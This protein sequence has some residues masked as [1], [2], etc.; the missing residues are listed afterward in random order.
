MGEPP[1]E[2]ARAQT[3]SLVVKQ[4]KETLDALPDFETKVAPPV[5]MPEGQLASS[6]A[7][8]GQ[9]AGAF[10]AAGI[11]PAAQ[12]YGGAVMSKTRRRIGLCLAAV[13]FVPLLFWITIESG[14]LV[15]WMAEPSDWVPEPMPELEMICSQMSDPI[16]W[17][18][19]VTQDPSSDS[20]DL[21]VHFHGRRGTARWWNDKTYYTAE[22]YEHWRAAGV[23]APT[24]VSISFGPLWVLTDEARDGFAGPVLEQARA[25]AELFAGHNFTRTR[26]VGESMGGYNAL[27]AALDANTPFDRV[28]ALCPPLTTTSPFGAGVFSRFGESSARE[29][30]MLLA[31]SRAFFD[32]DAD[33]RATDPVARVLAGESFEPS[34]FVSCGE[35][36]PWGCL[37]GGQALTDA[38]NAQGGDVQWR[39]LPEGH[40]AI[41]TQGLATFLTD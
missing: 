41:D 22:L 12:A 5:Q 13:A 1:R 21:L 32:D 39:V 8:I 14:V 27:I 26:L 17:S 37:K 24:V 2:G 11:R 29:G 20:R 23:E 35:H 38:V 25:H 7:E 40:C 33:W 34:L 16:P 19:C 31:F 10:F 3:P 28:A 4:S 6:A 15:R 36:D 18:L 9:G 30:F